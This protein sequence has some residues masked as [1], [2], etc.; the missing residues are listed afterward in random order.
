MSDHILVCPCDEALIS[1]IERKALVVRT[2]DAGWIREIDRLANARNKL[3]AVLLSSRKESLTGVPFDE[4]W[5]EIPIALHVA[6]LGPFNELTE[7]LA[8]LK[9]LNIRVFSPA[10]PE[11]I[12]ESRILASLG[13]D[14]GLTF[15]AEELDWDALDDLMHYSV[16]GRAG[17][18]TIEPFHHVMSHYDPRTPMDFDS[19]YFENP[20]R[21]LHI[22]E[23]ENIALNHAALLRG[24]FIAQGVSSLGSISQN[25]EYQAALAVW[26]EPFLQRSACAFCPAWRICLGKFA[27]R[28]GEDAG[29]RTLFSNLLDA[30]DSH[31]TREKSP[32]ASCRP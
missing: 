26:Q 8:L 14:C 19:V 21:Y 10:S 13:I 6:G 28:R 31:R 16:Y 2:D 23:N 15:E 1:R 17:R 20:R 29:C 27:G 18:G 22:D 24:E 4:D 11:G 25:D 9:E 12:R 5:R 7:R 3:H 32:R 30:A